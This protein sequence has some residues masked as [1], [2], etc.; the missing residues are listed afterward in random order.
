MLVIAMGVLAGVLFGLLTAL[1]RRGLMRQPNVLVG[2]MVI[3]SSAALM[4]LAVTILTGKGGD[5]LE[6]R[7][8][9]GYFA[10]GIVVPGISQILFVVAVREVGAS[11]TAIMIGTAPL[12]ATIIAV[13]FRGEALVIG[14]VVGTVLIVIGGA[15]LAWDRNLPPGFRARGMLFAFFCALLFAVRDNAVRMLDG[16]SDMDPRAAT[17]WTLIGAAVAVAVYATI[18][19]RGAVLTEYRSVFRSFIPAG[20]VFAL[21]YLAL[22]VALEIGR[23]TVFAP[24]NAMQSMWTVLFAW[25]L[26]GKSDG[27]G[28]RI[29][30]AMLL[31]VSGGILIGIFR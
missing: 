8:A 22:V 20:V 1:V 4:V 29:V 31:V 5:L 25:L 2:A 7:M 30:L 24:L 3:T 14:L 17:T 26:L 12:L 13:A 23:V 27:I 18:A 16:A 21:A 19:R 10:L 15:S 11:R 9:A 28:A 6:F